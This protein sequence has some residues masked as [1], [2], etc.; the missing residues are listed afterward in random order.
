[1]SVVQS[2]TAARMPH[3]FAI[4]TDSR[5][6]RLKE[7][8]MEVNNL[9]ETHAYIEVYAYPGATIHRL[10]QHI[11]TY[12]YHNFTD[13]IFLQAGICNTT[14]RDQQQKNLFFRSRPQ[15]TWLIQFSTSSGRLTSICII[16]TP[17]AILYTASL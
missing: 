10:S 17:K 2:I 3:R 1:M 5:G 12:L 11:R 15:Y 4:F 13:V 7:D 8:L 16:G 14:V 6:S 9:S